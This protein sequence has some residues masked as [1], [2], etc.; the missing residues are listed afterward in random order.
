MVKWSTHSESLNYAKISEMQIFIP[1]LRMI[2]GETPKI[3]FQALVNYLSL[4]I[5]LRMICYVV[6]RGCSFH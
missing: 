6:L 1:L 5:I 4:P 2:V 3:G